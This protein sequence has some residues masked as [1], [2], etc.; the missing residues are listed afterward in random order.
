MLSPGEDVDIALILGTKNKVLADLWKSDLFGVCLTLFVTN[1][2]IN[3]I[4]I[5]VYIS[6]RKTNDKYTK[7]SY[8]ENTPNE[9]V[10]DNA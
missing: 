3:G 9:G 4:T 1:T 8:G 6:I 7:I 10:N 2:S 5:Q